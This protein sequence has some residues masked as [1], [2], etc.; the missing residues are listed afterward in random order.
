MARP[1]APVRDLAGAFA[2][3]VLSPEERA[4]FLALIEVDEE[5]RAEAIQLVDT[6]ALIGASVP[7]VVPP[8]ALRARILAYAEVLPASAP[9]RPARPVDAPRPVVHLR[10]RQRARRRIVPFLAAAAAIAGLVSGGIGV[11][12]QLGTPTAVD[13]IRAAGDVHTVREPVD[14]GGTAEVLWSPGERRA[15]VTLAD[16]P[17]LS[18]GR[19]YELWF[20][21]GVGLATPAGVVTS[22]TMLLDGTL[23]RGDTIGVTIEPKGGSTAPTTPPI[24]QVET[25]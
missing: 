3:D 7:R 1:L 10:P 23:T 6:A 15:A 24:L 18:D 2:L 17:T 21:D 4:E 19:V 25:A 11:A 20:I 14:G 16:L 9:E 5:A 8:P 12:S 22:D 13:R